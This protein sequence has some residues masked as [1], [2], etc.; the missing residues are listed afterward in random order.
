MSVT[1]VGVR[2][3]SEGDNEDLALLLD[4]VLKAVEGSGV[5]R[6]VR[7]V[8]TV[9]P[10]HSVDHHWRRFRCKKQN[11]R[12]AKRLGGE[13]SLEGSNYR[14]RLR[15]SIITASIPFQQQYNK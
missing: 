5:S 13:G 2:G 9:L 7:S 15:S 4:P 11:Q 1:L 8:L 14:N 10:S 6:D 3:D 12:G